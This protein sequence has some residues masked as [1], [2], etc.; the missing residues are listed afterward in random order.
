MGGKFKS[1]MV[2]VFGVLASAFFLI[3]AVYE[4]VNGGTGM[5]VMM[6]FAMLCAIALSW[7]SRKPYQ[8]RIRFKPK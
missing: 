6:F 3:A 1:F 7:F 5:A 8:P 2:S 4:Y